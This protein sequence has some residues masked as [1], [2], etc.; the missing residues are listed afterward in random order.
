MF[1]QLFKNSLNSFQGVD[2]DPEKEKTSRRLKTILAAN[3]V[4]F[5]SLRSDLLQERQK[6]E[7]LEMKMKKMKLNHLKE[8]AAWERR[9][10][11]LD[12]EHQLSIASLKKDIARLEK[13][14]LKMKLER[15]LE[16]EDH[17]ETL[18]LIKTDFENQTTGWMDK[19]LLLYRAFSAK[20]ID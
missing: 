19:W 15:Q 3:S 14:K 4:V 18:Q 12:Y 16:I 17:L 1:V 2:A 8:K 11:E 6:S 10:Q 9:Q 20:N 5:D 7:Q 13:Q